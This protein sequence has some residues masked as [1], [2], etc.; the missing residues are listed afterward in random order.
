MTTEI[1]NEKKSIIEELMEENKETFSEKLL[2]DVFV[3]KEE[4]LVIILLYKSDSFKQI[5]KPFNLEILDKKMVD[6][7][8]DSCSNYE[9]KTILCDKNSNIISLIKPLLNDK[10]YTVVL[11][12]DTPLLSEETIIESIDF[13]SLNGMNVLKLPRGWIF[14]TEYIKTADS[15]SGVQSR[16][17]N[18]SEF[19]PVFNLKDLSVVADIKKKQIIDK[20]YKNEVI[21]IDEKTTYVGADVI[22]ESGTTIYPNNVIKGQTYIGK[23]CVIESFNYIT[24][25][26]IL[27]NCILKNS[28]IIRSKITENMVVGPFEFIENKQS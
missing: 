17:Y 2:K 13:F 22:I 8:K 23:N 5:K 15:I 18:E 26:I 14:K 27:N 9:V 28:N 7:V 1:I 25:S 24:D 16:I 12:S 11:Y 20:H 6:W 3:K 19:K 21:I 4:V 10:K